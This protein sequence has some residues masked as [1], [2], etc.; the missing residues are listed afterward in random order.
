M[1]ERQGELRWPPVSAAT[2]TATGARSASASHA[3]EGASQEPRSAWWLAAGVT[4]VAV[5]LVFALRPTYPNYDSYYSLV[6]G[7]ELASGDLPDY[8][9]FRTPTPHPL[10]TLLGATLAPLGGAADRL[11]VL[12]S[13]ATFAGVLVLV[14][15]FA[16][17]LLGT[18]VAA[19]GVVALLTRTDLWFLALRGVVDLQFL[20]LVLGAAV[21]ELRRPRRGWPVLAL[22]ALA[23]LVR[24]EAWVLSVAYLLWLL[25]ATPRERLPGYAALALL[26][27]VAWLASDWIVTG[28][29]L[30]SFTSTRAVAGE[31]E[32]QQGLFDALREMPAFLGGSEKLVNVVAGGAG[33]LLALWL[34]RRRAALPGAL[35]AIGLGLFVVIALAG[36]SVIPRYL[37]LP[38][39]LLTACVGVALAGWTAA[40][41]PRV[42]RV[43]VG[44]A[45]ACA[46][47]VAVRVPSYA[48][49]FEQLNDRVLA[50]RDQTRALKA[51]LDDPAV[52]PLLGACG[53][54]TVPNHS[55][56]PVVR[57]ET[58]VGEGGI[59]AATSLAEPPA[60]GL[61]LISWS[62]LFDPTYP[63]APARPPRDV[64][65]RWVNL[66]LAGFS[67]VA[68]NERWRVYARCE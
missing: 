64:R 10:A 41:V 33:S 36:L 31:V 37:L 44:V 28:E 49:D 47:L 55:S 46:A 30:Y 43:A 39:V 40:T 63:D 23:G 67:P 11:L 51:I 61:L 25:P 58:G 48:S 21:L 34:L 9:V 5:V 65:Q 2:Q 53:P 60:S 22:V 66:P 57:Y 17:L 54:I 4:F 62:F 8:E 68:A 38:S 6:W 3:E 50:S 27:P 45:V 19:V 14:F 52:V 59:R 13:L 26:A 1:I 7:A 42:R 35:L 20:A 56:V 18:V 15:R 32:R 29:P 16:Q 12:L 24:P